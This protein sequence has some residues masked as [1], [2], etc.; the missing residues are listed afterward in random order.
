M[1]K[2]KVKN[3]AKT[4]LPQTKLK[5]KVIA[6]YKVV[7]FTIITAFIKAK[8]INLFTLIDKKNKAA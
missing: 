1:L 5:Q 4:K 7:I 6:V 3:K 8:F 2:L